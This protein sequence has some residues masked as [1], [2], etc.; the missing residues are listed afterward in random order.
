M[1]SSVTPIDNRPR[2]IRSDVNYTQIVVDRTQALDGTFYDVMFVGTGGSRPPV[3]TLA[4]PAHLCCW[5]PAPPHGA[6][7]L[8]GRV[9]DTGLRGLPP[10]ES[11]PPSGASGTVRGGSH[12]GSPGG[13]HV[14]G[15]K[16]TEEVPPPRWP[17]TCPNLP[18]VPVLGGG[19]GQA[20]PQLA[21]AVV[22]A[23]GFP[24]SS[25]PG[26]GPS[27]HLTGAPHGTV[28]LRA[29]G[30]HEPPLLQSAGTVSLH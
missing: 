18:G 12:K 1:D 20:Q 15:L 21:G 30:A 13:A 27:P 14:G 24:A 17:K 22:R 7:V 19:G 26:G 28:P 4:E 16:A 5:G 29:I 2:L 23:G 11:W 8:Y 3:Q 25:E 6:T 10:R 9:S